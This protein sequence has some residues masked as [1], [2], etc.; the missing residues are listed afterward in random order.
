MHP[1]ILIIFSA[2]ALADSPPSS[3]PI[4][5]ILG[6]KCSQPG[7]SCTQTSTCGG[8]CLT[9][10]IFPPVIP[11]T[12]GYNSACPTG[13]TC[14]PTQ[15]C[16]KGPTAPC[17]GQCITTRPLPPGTSNLPT[18]ACEVGPSSSCPTNAFCTPTE[19]CNGVCG[20]TTP[21]ITNTYPTPTTTVPP[22]PS[23]TIGGNASCS[24]GSFCTPLANCFGFCRSGI[25]SPTTLPTATTPAPPPDT[26]ATNACYFG[27]PAND[28]GCPTSEYCVPTQTCPGLCLNT[29]PP[30]PGTTTTVTS[31]RPTTTPSATCGWTYTP[32]ENGDECENSRGK[33]CECGDS[34]HCVPEKEKQKRPRFVAGRYLN[35]GSE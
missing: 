28:G 20:S 5:C 3:T 19:I 22:L 12:I 31:S 2:L 24:Y 7:Y 23:C 35:E 30:P 34:G 6:N 16:T 21:T 15:Y 29:L 25:S 10:Q 33:K 26:T 14:T 27:R 17:G 18:I 11:C 8:L 1:F 4:P 32:C 9:S 13:S